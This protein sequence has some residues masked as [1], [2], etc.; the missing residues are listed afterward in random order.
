[1][2]GERFAII[3]A[4]SVLGLFPEGVRCCR[5]RYWPSDWPSASALAMADAS[6][7]RLTIQR[8]T[9][10]PCCSTQTPSPTTRSRSPTPSAPSSTGA[11][12]PWCSVGDCYGLA[13]SGHVASG[14]RPSGARCGGRGWPVASRQVTLASSYT[15]LLLSRAASVSLVLEPTSI[16]ANRPRAAGQVLTEFVAQGLLHVLVAYLAGDR[17]AVQHDAGAVA[18]ADGRQAPAPRARASGAGR[19]WPRDTAI[20]ALLATQGIRQRPAVRLMGASTSPHAV[21]VDGRLA[22]LR[23]SVAVLDTPAAPTGARDR[24]HAGRSRP[25]GR[26]RL[27]PIRTTTPAAR[28]GHCAASEAS[29]RRPSTVLAREVLYRSFANRRQLASYVDLARGPPEQGAR[30]GSTDHQLNPTQGWRITRSRVVSRGR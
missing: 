26:R 6:N 4:P 17:Q 28:S 15:E 5:T 11:S 20:E 22:S 25:S 19:G 27:P 2:T 16:S 18:D 7:R 21:A 13:R 8:A 29:A 14:A 30:S 12:S 23:I 24:D 1:M 9:P 10:R 3:E